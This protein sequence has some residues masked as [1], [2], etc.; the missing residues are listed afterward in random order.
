MRSYGLASYDAV[1]AA[2]AI[3]A[4][5]PVMVTLDTHF[6]SLP[7]RTLHVY[8]DAGRVIACRLKRPRRR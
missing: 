4:G 3:E 6:A 7:Q 2:T 1:H 5:V 8:T